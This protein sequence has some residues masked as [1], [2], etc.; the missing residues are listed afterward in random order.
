MTRKLLITDYGKDYG[1]G[2]YAVE[3]DGLHFNTDDY[4]NVIY[5]VMNFEKG[6]TQDGTMDTCDR[7]DTT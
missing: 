6:E 3:I 7:N 4:N 1:Y 5:L 2:R